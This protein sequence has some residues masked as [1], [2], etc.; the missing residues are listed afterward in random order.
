MT[1][2]RWCAADGQPH[3]WQV[4]LG[5]VHVLQRVEIDFEYPTQA[6]GE[7]YGYVVTVSNDGTTFSAGID[8]SANAAT[9]PTQT[10]MFPANTSGR[11]VRILVTP[12]ATSPPTWASFW[13][14]RIYGY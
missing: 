14:A 8:Q 4:D 11:H 1:G 3:Y 10:A 13:E 6:D 2:T 5:A 12:P 7:S 9:T